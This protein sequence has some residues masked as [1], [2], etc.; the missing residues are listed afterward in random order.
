MALNN[1]LNTHAH[2][3]EQFKYQVLLDHLKL[4]SAYKL[5]QAYMYHPKPYTSALQALKDKYGQ[6]CQLVQSELG[7][8]LNSPHVRSGDLEAFGNFVLSVQG[9][10]G[11]L[12]SLEGENGYELR[13]S[14][15]V[16]RLLSKL[17]TN[18]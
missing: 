10:V 4:P 3:T 17:S 1:L 7:A 14:S 16:D 13:C 8:I 5:A 9:L 18:Y 15:H 6:P 2:F 11:M 12:R